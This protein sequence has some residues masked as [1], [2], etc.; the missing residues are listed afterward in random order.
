MTLARRVALCYKEAGVTGDE[1]RHLRDRLG[2]TQALLAERLGVHRIT[3]VRWEQGRA[4]IPAAAA[5]LVRLFTQG[6]LR[7]RKGR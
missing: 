4:R 6:T 3:L 2:L 5:E 7:R 1:L